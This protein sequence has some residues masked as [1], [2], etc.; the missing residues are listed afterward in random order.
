[1]NEFV[2]KQNTRALLDSIPL[3]ILYNYL[4]DV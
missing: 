4:L 2:K 1:M 3:C